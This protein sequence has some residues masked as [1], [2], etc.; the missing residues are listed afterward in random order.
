MDWS[1]SSSSSRIDLCL[2]SSVWTWGFSSNINHSKS[3]SIVLW[4]FILFMLGLLLNLRRNSDVWRLLW[5]LCFHYYLPDIYIFWDSL[6]FVLHF[7]LLGQFVLLFSLLGQSVL[8]TTF[9]LTGTVR[10]L[11][12]LH[13]FKPENY[14]YFYCSFYIVQF[15]MWLLVRGRACHLTSV[16]IVAMAPS[17]VKISENQNSELKCF[18]LSRHIVKG[19]LGCRILIFWFLLVVPGGP[20]ARPGGAR[21]SPPEL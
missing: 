6:Y 15:T 13:L 4:N 18:I 12:L 5:Y 19:L 1:F 21:S 17:C 11:Y 9:Q 16:K 8:C 2:S 3:P 20:G 7:S 10:T 14:R